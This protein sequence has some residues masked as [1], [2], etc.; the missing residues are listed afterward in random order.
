MQTTLEI[1]GMMCPRCEAHVKKS[2]LALDGVQS[3]TVSHVSG[4]ATIESAKPISQKLL[5]NTIAELG[6]KCRDIH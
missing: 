3:V 2:L 4:T 6:Y 1:D 5:R